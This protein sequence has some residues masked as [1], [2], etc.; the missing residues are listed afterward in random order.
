MDY[1]SKERQYLEPSASASGE[2][3]VR[4]ANETKNLSANLSK[5]LDAMH[6]ELVYLYERD[7]ETYADDVQA[8]TLLSQVVASVE[9]GVSHLDPRLLT[10]IREFLGTWDAEEAKESVEKSKVD[11]RKRVDELN[12]M[13]TDQDTLLQVVKDAADRIIR[14]AGE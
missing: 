12:A 9:G 3:L 1:E 8:N 14:Q 2:F 13:F 4:F 6:K 7:D 10:E 5:S 11:S